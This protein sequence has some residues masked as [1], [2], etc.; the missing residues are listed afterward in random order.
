MLSTG[1]ELATDSGKCEK[2]NQIVKE[3]QLNESYEKHSNSFDDLIDSSVD[4]WL[5]KRIMKDLDDIDERNKSKVFGPKITTENIPGTPMD[6]SD[7][8]SE[9]NKSFSSS[10]LSMSDRRRSSS[11][12]TGSPIK[13]GSS[14]E[15]CHQ[16]NSHNNNNENEKHN[17]QYNHV[18]HHYRKQKDSVDDDRRPSKQDKEG[19]D[20][21]SLMFRD[22][23]RKID[24]I[25]CY[26]EENE[27]VMTEIE[28][29]KRQQ[30]K[31]FQENLIKEGLEI[32]VEDKSQAFDEKTFF[33]K[34][35][36]PWRTET[37]YA[38]VLNL[39]LPVKRFITISV[40]EEESKFRKHQN[41]W[42]KY[43]SR[44]IK[45]CEYDHNLIPEEPTFYE[46]TASGPPEEQ[47]IVKDRCTSYNSAQRSLIVMQ[48]M[49]RTR[50]DETE[51][52]N[53]VG[54]RRLL[55]DGTYLACFPLHEGRYEKEHSTG[56]VFDRRVNFKHKINKQ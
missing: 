9:L 1:N 53:N 5:D 35:H 34:I 28:A 22:G 48:I 21:E 37:R 15:N 6:N 49:L 12:L 16:S 30:R 31:I 25:I 7:I 51:K 10:I 46:S 39:K 47:F 14:E 8:V 13:T 52:L 45:V 33:I 50:F 26:E 54:I 44:V 55:N 11:L 41:K 4:K 17:E 27:G 24:M 36:I 32:E 29:I 38:E 43:W 3:N 23:R 40:K 20:A 2:D 56:S 19:L 42:K 18:Q